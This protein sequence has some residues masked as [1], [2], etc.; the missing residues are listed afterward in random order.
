MGTLSRVLKFMRIWPL[1]IATS[2]LY[3]EIA[4]DLRSRGQALS[5]IDIMLAALCRELDLSLVTSDKVFAALPWL[6]TE[7]WT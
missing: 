3:G 4:N 7:Q 2:R 1:T 6:K 5:Q